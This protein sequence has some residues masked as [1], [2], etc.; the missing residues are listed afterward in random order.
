MD[1]LV[2]HYTQ[3][4]S[5][6][7]D[8]F[9]S[10]SLRELIQKYIIGSTILDA[11]CGSGDVTLF[12]NKL[13]YNVYSFD[14]EESMVKL[15]DSL[16]ESNDCIQ[17]I[18][19]KSISQLSQEMPGSFD[20][21]IN[22]DVIEHI[23]DDKLAMKQL[24]KML[25]PNGRLILT[26]PAHKALFGPKDKAIGHYRRYSKE[27]LIQ[28]AQEN[29]LQI[30]LIRHWNAIGALTTYLNLKLRGNNINESFRY[31]RKF[32]DTL[33]NKI[34]LWWFRYFERRFSLP[35]GSSLIVVADAPN[36][37]TRD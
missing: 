13:S 35:F 18:H 2:S 17:E 19:H 11:G 9:R 29:N 23:D 16:L 37:L 15:A 34:L 8:D 14:S 4:H 10:K 27:M 33:L 31:T 6:V 7:L 36:D 12:L 30:K 5:N 22:L 1:T 21:I 3:K 28:L 24:V 20:T 32:S 26:V 25:R